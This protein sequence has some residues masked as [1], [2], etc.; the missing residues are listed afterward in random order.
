MVQCSFKVPR[1]YNAPPTNKIKNLLELYARRKREIALNE[2]QKLLE[3]IEQLI[4][5]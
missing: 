2:N 3:L 5:L 4:L 1:F